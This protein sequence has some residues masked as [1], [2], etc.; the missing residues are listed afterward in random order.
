MMKKILSSSLITLFLSLN[1]PAE[2]NHKNY[3]IELIDIDPSQIEY[4]D[5]KP[6]TSIQDPDLE[7]ASALFSESKDPQK[8]FELSIQRQNQEYISSLG[9]K[10]K[11]FN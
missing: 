2:D 7:E 9:F 3:L 6:K 11:S 1:L 4:R 8:S 10:N 5:L